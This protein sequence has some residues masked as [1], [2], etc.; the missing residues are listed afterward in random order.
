[1]AFLIL[2][3]F[4]RFI[5]T[6]KGVGF[7]A[8]IFVIPPKPQKSHKLSILKQTHLVPLLAEL[9]S[10]QINPLNLKYV[11]QKK[12]QDTI[13]PRDVLLGNFS[14]FVNSISKPLIIDMVCDFEELLFN[15][16]VRMCSFDKAI[17]SSTDNLEN[18]LNANNL[19]FEKFLTREWNLSK[20]YP[21]YVTLKDGIFAKLYTATNL[22]SD[23]P[24]GWIYGLYN[25]ADFVR[26][27]INPID[28]DKYDKI[29]NSH[30]SVQATKS[31]SDEMNQT[32]LGQSQ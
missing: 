3:V 4:G 21:E 25:M 29:I 9:N 18:I 19:K 8:L 15:R 30:K 7:L 14:N 11:S 28:N 27:F 12:I 2:E 22:H 13:S 10:Y 32:V 1:M 5:P 20:E 24:P 6:L 31:T 17:F 16:T 26:V 23:L